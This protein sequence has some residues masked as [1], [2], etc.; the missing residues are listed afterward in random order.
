MVVVTRAP[1]TQPVD[2]R[3]VVLASFNIQSGHNGGLESALRAMD[4]LGVE[5]GFLVET[6]LTA[7]IYTRFSSGYS[8]LT[9]EAPSAWQGGIA[10]FWR[11]NNLYKIKETQIWGSNVISLHLIVGSTRFLLWGATSHPLI[12]KHWCV[13]KQPDASVL[14]GLIPFWLAT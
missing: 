5:L 1:S 14:W 6:K 7:G 11:D 12:W 13:S 4:N 8:V 10:L 2:S 9:S 3:S